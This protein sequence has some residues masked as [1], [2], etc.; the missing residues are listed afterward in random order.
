M[1]EEKPEYVRQYVI[2][3]DGSETVE[4]FLE[5][6]GEELLDAQIPHSIDGLKLVHRRTL[7]IIDDDS[8]IGFSKTI[9]SI[10]Q[11]LNL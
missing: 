4:Y 3:K 11:L 6:Y 9:R 2:P 5:N 7:A 8:K 1:Q 10:K